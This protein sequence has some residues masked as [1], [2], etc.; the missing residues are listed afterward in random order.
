MKPQID[1]DESAPVVHTGDNYNYT[2]ILAEEVAAKYQR[3]GSPLV[4]LRPPY[5]YGP[6]DR[7]LFPRL[8]GNLTSGRFKYI[9]SGKNPITFCYA[10]NLVDAMMLAAEK[11]EAL[12]ETFIITDGESITR[13]E[14]VDIIC[15]HLETK[16][17]TRHVP[18]PVARAAMPIIE[19]VHR[20]LRLKKTPLLN[21]FKFKFMHTP[22]TFDITKAKT[23]LG[24]APRMSTREGLALSVDWYRENVMQKGAPAE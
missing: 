11:P 21:R 5:L 19:A 10:G 7:Q 9:G 2:K 6:R 17:P 1:L 24:Y 20:V 3:N 23:Q 18:V 14:M 8:V 12:G 22:L 16:A 15:E 4:I 13:Q